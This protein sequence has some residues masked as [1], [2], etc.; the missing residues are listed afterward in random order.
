MVSDSVDVDINIT[1]VVGHDLAVVHGHYHGVWIWN[2]YQHLH[3]VRHRL[4]LADIHKHVDPVAV[5]VGV[6]DVDAIWLGVDVT[7][8]H[9][10]GLTL[11]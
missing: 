3:H 8:V 5:C 11:S 4:D 1:V 6:V 9:H 7:I 10:H 2:V